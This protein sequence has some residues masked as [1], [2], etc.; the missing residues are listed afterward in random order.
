MPGIRPGRLGA[1]VGGERD[2]K[3]HAMTYVIDQDDL[4]RLVAQV[5]GPVL[6]PGDDGYRTETAAWNAALVQRPA[7]AVGAT[8][9]A[10]VAAAVRFASERALPVAMLATGHGAVLASDG[11]VMINLSRINGISVD[12]KSGTATIGAAV[13][14]QQL[15][16]A[17]AQVGLAPLAGSSPNVGVVGYVLGGGLSPSLGRVHGFAADHVRDAEIVCADGTPRRVDPDHD[18]DLFWAIRGGQGNFGVVT[19]LTIDLVPLTRLYGGGLYFSGE[20]VEQVLDAFRQLAAAAPPE[21]TLS[22]AFMRLPST[23]SVPEPLRDRFAVHVRITYL[24][25]AADGQRLVADLRA[26]APTLID[27]VAEM[28]YTAIATVHADPVDPV[29]TYEMSSLLREFPVAAARALVAVAGPGVDSPVAMIEV[30]QLGGALAGEPRVPNAVGNRDAAFQLSAAAF[31]APGMAERFRTPLAELAEALRPWAT[32]RRQAN[33]LTGYDTTVEAVA[34]AYE[35]DT[36][37][38]LVEIKRAFD[39]HNTFRVNHNIA[40]P[41]R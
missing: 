36:Y 15:I 31:G 40:P 16:D 39:P 3:G 38:R 37:R 8:S 28:P 1:R 27:T 22:V 18:P 2:Q 17:A 26:A 12:A 29:A 4:A 21:L 24:G 5:A 32:G 11:A 20:H 25:P 19:S 10:D 9:V 6:V 7:V 23:P 30:R 34:R 33:F 14:A 41:R 13:R 35:P